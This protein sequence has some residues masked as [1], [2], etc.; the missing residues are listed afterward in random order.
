MNSIQSTEPIKNAFSPCIEQKLEIQIYI[1]RIDN[2]RR[3]LSAKGLNFVIEIIH[4]LV[5]GECLTY[6]ELNFQLG[7]LLT[8]FGAKFTAG[9]LDLI[10]GDNPRVHLFHVDAEG[11]ICPYTELN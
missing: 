10:I 3:Y 9:L 8:G 4:A 6:E 11:I 2:N 7:K 5:Q 1:N